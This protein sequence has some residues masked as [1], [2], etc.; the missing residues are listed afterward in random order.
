MNAG[1]RLI[2]TALLAQ[3]T[4]AVVLPF[5]ATGTNGSAVLTGVSTTAGLFQG[6]PVFGPG[7]VSMATI[8]SVNTG[9]STLTLSDP[10]TM[11]GTGEAFTTGFLTTGGRVQ[12]WSECTE[13]PALFLRR[14]G[15]HD[16]DQG[17]GLIATTMDFEAWIYVNSGQNPDA[18]PDDML[19][20]IEQL[21]RTALAPS[22]YDDDEGRFTLR[23]A[24]AALGLP[25]IH[26]CR[27]EGKTDVATGDQG[28]QAILR[29]PIRVTLP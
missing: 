25:P 14:T 6:F 28:P 27:I 2:K 3:L 9:A 21:V 1:F 17:D 23:T 4:G 20:S 10:L 8:A 12:H 11:S 29:I 16:D 5:T 24:L 19:V 13:Q 26:W 18:D 22:L 15:V 7:A